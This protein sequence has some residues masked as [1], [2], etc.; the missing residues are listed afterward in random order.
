MI[1]RADLQKE[2]QK[3]VDRATKGQSLLLNP[4]IPQDEL[5]PGEWY[6]GDCY[7]THV[8]LWDGEFFTTFKPG[9]PGLSCMKTIG[10]TD[11]LAIRGGFIPLKRIPNPR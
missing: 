7:L 5:T 1:K 10:Y 2:I 8:A 9:E 6:I 11:S 4:A 3:K